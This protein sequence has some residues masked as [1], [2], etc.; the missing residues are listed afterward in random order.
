MQRTPIWLVLLTLLLV[1]FSAYALYPSVMLYSMSADERARLEQND[2]GK[3]V[4]L[5]KRA[6]KLGLDLRGGMHVVLEVDKSK[7]ND[8]EKLDA[9]DRAL[10]VIRNRVD[11]FGV[12]EP[13]IQKS[14]E[15]R[16]IVELPGVSDPQR[17]RELIGRTAQ[18]EFKLM[19]EPADQE[20]VI[21]TIDRAVAQAL[22]DEMAALAEGTPPSERPISDSLAKEL[23]SDSSKTTSHDSAAALA[24]ADTSGKASSAGD[25][26]LAAQPFSLLLRSSGGYGFSVE[27]GDVPTVKRYLALPE[28]LAAIPRGI[29]LAWGIRE[30]ANRGSVVQILYVLNERAELTGQYLTDAH[31]SMNQE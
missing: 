15:D 30:S 7:L 22:P 23:F 26:A 3:L 13:L 1:A 20:A 28:V 19:P 14:G 2:P 9:V 27:E 21:K 10:E 29:Q 11:Q 24:S 8:K 5:E 31:P 12:A 16:I 18:L 6:I 4:D 25:S 17:A